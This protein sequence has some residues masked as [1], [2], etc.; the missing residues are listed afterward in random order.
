[1]R[2]TEKMTSM[3]VIGRKDVGV[4]CSVDWLTGEVIPSKTRQEYK[5]ECD[6]NF[7]METY[8]KAGGLLP[9]PNRVG[10][11]FDFTNVPTD[12]AGVLNVMEEAGKAFATLD[13]RVRFEFKNDPRQF[14]DFASNPEN[15]PQLVTWGLA[16]AEK[17][18]QGP[19]EVRVVQ[20]QAAQAAAPAPSQGASHS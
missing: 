18:P 12:L 2:Q 17:A 5:D 15:L 9:P 20:D 7:M 11:Y 4:D 1:M 8:Q 10:E 6:I 13:P 19:I 14:V 16:E 3:A